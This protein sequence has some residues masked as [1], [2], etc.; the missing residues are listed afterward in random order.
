MAQAH[1]HI[2][3]AAGKRVRGS[4][5]NYAIVEIATGKTVTSA[6]TRRD[7]DRLRRGVEQRI[8]AAAYK[9]PEVM[10]AKGYQWSD[11]LGW[12]LIPA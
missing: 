8:R 2:V 3:I 6:R 11:F 10:R 4:C 12:V 7:A 9:D 1:T 5:K